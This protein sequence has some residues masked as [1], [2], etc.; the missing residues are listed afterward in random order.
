MKTGL[1]KSNHGY[2]VIK[3]F[4]VPSDSI[5]IKEHEK[6]LE[7]VKSKLDPEEQP[8]LAPF[9]VSLLFTIL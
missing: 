2:A 3:A 6:Y 1:G 4:Q 7:Y 9:S 5:H 8:N